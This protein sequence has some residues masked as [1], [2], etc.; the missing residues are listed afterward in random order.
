MLLVLDNFEQVTEAAGVVAQLLS[1]CPR[2]TVLATSR[3]ALHVRAEQVYPVPPLA[4]PPAGR[5]RVVGGGRSVRYEAVQL[6][7]DRA[8]RGP[9]RLRADR[10]Q[11]RG[12]RRHLPPARRPAPR[13]RARG[14]AP[15]AVLPRGAPGSA[16]RSA[17]APA[18][19]AARPARSA[20]RRCGRRW[21]GATSSSSPA[22]SGCSSCWRCSRTRRSPRSRR[23]PTTW[24]RSTASALDVLDGLAG[25]VEKSLVRRVDVPGGEPRVAMLETIR[26]FAA[27]RLDQRPDSALR[28]RRAHATYFADDGAPAARGPDRRRARGRARRAGRRRREPADRLGPLG[29]GTRPRAAR[30]AGRH[31]ADPRRCPRLVPRHRRPDARTCSPSSRPSRRRPTGSARR[32]PCGRASPGR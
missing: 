16:G 5:G 29:G 13:D 6:F 22:S 31:P 3:E 28:A 24:A 10:R 11:R 19:R 9:P 20:S 32:S 27:D 14:G 8:R 12:R 25:L 15:A 26:E 7:V 23:W 2:L 21:T 1:E 30:R 17:G 4:L 18:Q